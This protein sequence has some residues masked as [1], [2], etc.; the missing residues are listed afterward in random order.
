MGSYMN[1]SGH[2][3]AAP[4]S[5]KARLSPAALFEGAKLGDSLLL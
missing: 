4:N 1:S 3:T 2:I 5:L